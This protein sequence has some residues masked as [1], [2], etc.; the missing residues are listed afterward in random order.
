M[1]SSRRSTETP[2]DEVDHELLDSSSSPSP[3][4]STSPSRS[5]SRHPS[6]R[7]GETAYHDGHS[8]GDTG[9]GKLDGGKEEESQ[10]VDR[11][12]KKEG[13]SQGSPDHNHAAAEPVALPALDDFGGGIK[14][15]V[16]PRI[17]VSQNFDSPP[18][19]ASSNHHSSPER[20]SAHPSPVSKN[21]HGPSDH[22]NESEEMDIPGSFRV[23]L[24]KNRH[25]HYQHHH[26][27][28]WSALFRKL[29]LK[30]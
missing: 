9:E 17:E 7:A 21:V 20:H 15:R 22:D 28:G 23:E 25:H 11:V 29:S 18:S 3:D 1:N 12:P 16:P 30:S 2:S 4:G 27:G 26:G 10:P 8:G 14:L 5:I 24:R 6:T 13:V 19:T